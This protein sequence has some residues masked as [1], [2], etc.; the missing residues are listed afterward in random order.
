MQTNR[1]L[2]SIL[3]EIVATGGN[4]NPY[5]SGFVGGAMNPY[6]GKLSKDC[7]KFYPYQEYI[8]QNFGPA[9]SNLDKAGKK[10]WRRQRMSQL[11]AQWRA[12]PG[13]D[14]RKERYK[15]W[16][17][18]LIGGSI[19][20]MCKSEYHQFASDWWNDTKQQY[21]AR[22]WSPQDV[23]K[24]NRNIA[25]AWRKK[26]MESANPRERQYLENYRYSDKGYYAPARIQKR[27]SNRAALR[28]FYRQNVKGSRGVP[29][30]S[31]S[32]PRGQQLCKFYFI[33]SYYNL[34]IIKRKLL[35]LQE[36]HPITRSLIY[37]HS[38]LDLHNMLHLLFQNHLPPPFF[39]KD[40]NNNN[41]QEEGKDHFYLMKMILHAQQN[42]EDLFLLVIVLLMLD[43]PKK[44]V[45]KQN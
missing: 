26:K 12:G 27:A 5:G 38:P 41:S 31:V 20:K 19:P 37:L 16:G 22:I 36:H 10:Q 40:K 30:A 33:K 6:G 44:W 18:G 9:P 7:L 11:A 14:R 3:E 4:M 8:S 21:P 23:I 45:E 17:R 2:D 25:A 28:Q 29:I 39:M 34:L 15:L 24:V 35:N 1:K 32:A 13:L 42:I 43:K